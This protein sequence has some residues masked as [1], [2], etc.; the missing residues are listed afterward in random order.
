M[1]WYKD[2]IALRI[3]AQWILFISLVV[4][5]LLLASCQPAG[6]ANT[7]V[8]P[9]SSSTSVPAGNSQSP[10]QASSQTVTLVNTSFDPKQLTVPVGTTV[11]WVNK[12]SMAH[13]VTADDK[14]FNSGNLNSGETFKFTFTK[15]GTFPY[16]CQYHGGPKGVGMSGVIT[17]TGQ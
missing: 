3:K 1:N 16:Y 14:S 11:V 15:A 12:D 10:T 7:N 2:K 4:T 8:S 13:T 17:V 6:L 9:T 5:M